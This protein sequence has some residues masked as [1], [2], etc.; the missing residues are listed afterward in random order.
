M[1]LF[2]SYIVINAEM[3]A[4]INAFALLKE[5][6]APF[7]N[8]ERE[9]FKVNYLLTLNTKKYHKSFSVI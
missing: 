8:W 2:Y 1:I 9:G 6:D 7:E 3:K 5:I 4:W